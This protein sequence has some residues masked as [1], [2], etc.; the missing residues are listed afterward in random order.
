MQL[1]IHAGT[2][3]IVMKGGPGEAI[4]YPSTYL[5]EVRPVKSG[6]RLVSITFI[7]SLIKDEHKRTQ[8][9]EL[10]EVGALESQKMSWENRVRLEVVCQ[11][12][13]RMWS[14]R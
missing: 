13:L 8:L 1:V 14:D 7:E 9:Y 4:V 11:N 3:P 6:R 10:N 2:H 5:H 12:L